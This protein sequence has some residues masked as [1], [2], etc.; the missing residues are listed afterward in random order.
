MGS[1]GPQP[2]NI[3]WDEFDKLVSYQCTQVEVAAFFD[4]ST[5]W[6]EVLCQRHRGL[7][8]SEVWDKRKMLGR[9]RLRK[10]QFGIVERGGSGA[11]T[12]AIWLDKKMFPDENPD[13]ELP[14]SPPGSLGGQTRTKLTF[15][16]FCLNASYPAPFPKQE[17]MRAFVL[18]E[19]EARMLLGARGVGKTDYATVMGTAYDVYEE[20]FDGTFVRTLIMSKSKSRNAAM[21][22]EIA[23][24]LEANGVPLEKENTSCIRVQGLV[25]KDHSVE[26]I[27]IRTSMR[28]RHP[29]RIIMDDPVTDEDVSEA[30][31]LLVKRKYNEA[32]KLTS[33]V[34]VI[35]QPAHQRDLYAELR[36]L[37]TMKRLEVPHG[38]IPELDHDL[39]AQRLAGVDE[40]TIQASYHLKIITDG[41]TFFSNIKYI[42]SLPA[43][44]KVAFI[45]PSDGGD[46]TAISLFKGLVGGM[47]VEGYVWK[48][49]WYHCLD[50]IIAICKANGVA[51]I[52]FETNMTGTQPIA[53]LRDLVKKLGLGIGIVG[54]H[55]DSNKHALIQAAGSYSHMIHLSRKSDKTY[56]DHVVNYEYKAKYDDAPDSLARGLE[57]M[58]LL[59]GKK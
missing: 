35:G 5:D 58:G 6:L 37:K 33:N 24:A 23:K 34:C 55:S 53:Q 32:L 20:W 41:T 42:D 14:P 11:A 56:A 21:V 39:E 47:G 40:N 25:G 46:Y 8:L 7:K 1:R 22:E 50:D 45:D 38:M 48:K 9:V 54:S 57:W 16:Q 13:R 12:M 28:G 2:V 10:A 17:E 30:M 19:T 31:R 27:T 18:D 43:G 15:T 3:N 26:A 49:A 52:C 51:R 44:P 59:K 4:I 29:D 36:G